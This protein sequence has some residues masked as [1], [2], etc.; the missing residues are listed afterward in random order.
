MPSALFISITDCLSPSPRAGAAVAA[1]RG[2]PNGEGISQTAGRGAAQG[3]VL[4]TSLLYKQKLGRHYLFPKKFYSQILSKRIFNLRL[5]FEGLSYDSASRGSSCS[6]SAP[7]N[8]KGKGY[9]ME[10]KGELGNGHLTAHW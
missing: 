6:D 10:S 5:Q 4:D 7:G 2:P 1:H 9:H 3:R 8:W